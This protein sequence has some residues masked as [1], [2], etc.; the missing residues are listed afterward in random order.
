MSFAVQPPSAV[1]Q[2]GGIDEVPR[3]A[4]VN[5]DLELGPTLDK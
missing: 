2:S 4:F 5:V 3:S 1:Q